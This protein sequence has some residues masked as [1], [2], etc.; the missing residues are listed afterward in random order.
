MNK[1]EE[2]IIDELY[3]MLID[4]MYHMIMTHGVGFCGECGELRKRCEC[5]IFTETSNECD[6]KKKV[7]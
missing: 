5:E 7:N 4:K 1:K 2:K 3:N 6:C